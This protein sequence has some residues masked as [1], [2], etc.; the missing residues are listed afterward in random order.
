MIG[1]MAGDQIKKELDQQPQSNSVDTRLGL[2][3]YFMCE[4]VLLL[5][6]CWEELPF[7]SKTFS[8]VY[9]SGQAM[10]I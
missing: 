5:A 7:S 2:W 1:L 4:T 6:V 9:F 10:R 8:P 3:A